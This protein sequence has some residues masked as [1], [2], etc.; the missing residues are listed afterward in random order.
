VT[1]TVVFDVNILVSAV[2]A[3]G[4]TPA[5][6]LHAAVDR[7]WDIRRS[8]PI[9]QRLVEATSRSRFYGRLDSRLVGEFLRVFQQYAIV[10]EPDLSVAGVCDDEEDDLVLGTAVAANADFLVTGDKGL[11][12]IAEYRGVRIA[13][14]TTFLDVLNGPAVGTG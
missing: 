10:L 3:P 7:G 14:A 1:G 9:V 4:G 8:V 11:L 6:T 5:L 13:S 12:R 2:L